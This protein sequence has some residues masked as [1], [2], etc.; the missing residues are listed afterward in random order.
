MARR[1]WRSATLLLAVFLLGAGGW[2]AFNHP[3]RT[4]QQEA[5]HDEGDHADHGSGGG[6][7][8]TVKLTSQARKNL[9]LV[10]KPLELTTYWR[11]IDLPGV[12]VDRP[13]ISD[14]GVVAPVT[15]VVTRV[16]A[17]PGDTVSPNAPLFSI[18]LASDSLHASQLE[19]FKAAREIEIARSQ[20]KRLSQA[21]Q[22]GA[23]AQ[24]RIIEMEN[25]IERLDAT[26]LAYRQDLKAHSLTADDIESVARGEFITE[27][28]VK[29][30]TEQALRVSEVA[31][32]SA[33][34]IDPPQLPFSFEMQ[35][36]NVELGQQVQA[37]SVLCHLAD[38]RALMIEGRGFKDD[39]PLLQQAVSNG[40]EV[41]VE[42]ELSEAAGSWPPLPSRIPI[43]H[44]ANSVDAETRTFTFFLPLS[45]QWRTYDQSGRTRLLW[46]FRP[47]GRVRLRIPVEKFANVLVVPKQAVYREGPEAYVFRQ[48][49][50]YFDRRPVHILYEDRLNVALANDISVRSGFFI[51]QSGAA[52]LNRVLKSQSSQG[53]APGLHVHADG[54]VH[55]AH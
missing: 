4:E 35:S 30:P 46:R 53:A 52:S 54:T 8:E 26:V 15:G 49:G 42:Y 16:H 19:L 22:S 32:A 2:W 18:R 29:A 13:G 38:H 36:L 48:N 40:W 20:M 50:D 51:A 37:G 55:E 43:Q 47:G 45:N 44:I 33:E 9:A 23:L 17:F 11:T 24:S 25:Q 31:L 27:I 39:M 41:E 5:H 7:N 12:I 34:E 1:A 14:R 3:L 21:A 10:S 28:V 6:A